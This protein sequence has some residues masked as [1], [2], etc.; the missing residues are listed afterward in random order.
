[1]YGH[2]KVL[3]HDEPGPGGYEVP[4]VQSGYPD[5][6][7]NGVPVAEAVPVQGYVNGGAPPVN[8]MNANGYFQQQTTPLENGESLVTTTVRVGGWS[9]IGQT[10][11]FRIEQHPQFGEALS[12]MFIA[13]C[14]EFENTYFVSDAETGTQLLEVKE[15]S[16]CMGRMCCAPQHELLLH[17]YD[18]R[19]GV[20]PNT[21]VFSAHKPFKC[22]NCFSCFDFCRGDLEI[23]DAQGEQLGRALEQGCLETLCQPKVEIMEREEKGSFLRAEGPVCLIGGCTELCYETIFA[24]Y[25]AGDQSNKPQQ[26]GQIIKEMPNTMEDT[27]NEAITQADNFRVEVPHTHT[28]PQKIL[29]LASA[30]LLDYMFFETGSI[31]RPKPNGGVNIHCCNIYC[32]GCLCPVK[33]SCG[34]G[35][36][37]HRSY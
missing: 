29:T 11:R 24:L 14:I 3:P 22:F 10:N 8:E 34:G 20:P 26:V 21:L 36:G 23:F 9:S 17:A 5:R 31:I 37:G 1:M 13:N 4:V 12:Q 32:C 19:P 15:Q 28:G 16:D 25:D 33:G 7:N 30:I 6:Q 18:A 27:C 2:T 35:G